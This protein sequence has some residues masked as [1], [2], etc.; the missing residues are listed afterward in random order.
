MDNK[1]NL[2]MDIYERNDFQRHT[3]RNPLCCIPNFFLLILIF[4]NC[5]DL[6]ETSYIGWYERTAWAPECARKL[7]LWVQG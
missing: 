3:V 6:H 4:V 2:Y 1:Y 5:N 7:P